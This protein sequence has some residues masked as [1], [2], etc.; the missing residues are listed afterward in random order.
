LV[1]IF[2]SSNIKEVIAHLAP[3]LLL[4]F[5]LRRLSTLVRDIIYCAHKYMPRWSLLKFRTAQIAKR[6][7]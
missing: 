5:A 1:K 7:Y 6:G 4:I 2:D 3:R